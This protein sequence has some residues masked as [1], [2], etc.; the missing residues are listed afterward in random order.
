LYAA[1]PLPQTADNPL[2]NSNYNAVNPTT[3]TVP[4]I[5]FRL[6]H[7]INQ[8]KPV[9]V[10]FT[11]VDHSSRALRNYPVNSRPTSKAAVFPAGA[12]GYQ[13][14]PIQDYQPCAGYSHI[15]S[16]TFFSETIISQQW[17]GCTFRATRRR[18][19]TTNR[20]WV[21][22]ITSARS[23]SRLGSANG[24]DPGSAHALWRFAMVLR[25]EQMLATLDEI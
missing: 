8:N 17:R 6:D 21:C 7:V 13:A 4:N 14:Q 22:P 2:V 11:D 24:S 19:R 12:T 3:Q 20:N 15:F 5:T 18:S 10:R 9:Y 1:T 16:P 23:D 25:H